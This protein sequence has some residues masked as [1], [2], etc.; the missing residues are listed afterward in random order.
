MEKTPTWRDRAKSVIAEAR[1]DEKVIELLNEGKYDEARKFI[2]LKFYPFTMRKYYPY[3][4]WLDELKK[5]FSKPP[6]SSGYN[7]KNQ[8]T[9]FQRV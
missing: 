9:I 1:K 7:P 3:Q 8:L 6:Q 2:S 4:V 5:Q